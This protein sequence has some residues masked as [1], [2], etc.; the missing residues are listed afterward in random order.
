[1]V[2][3][4]PNFVTT[5]DA[6]AI[7][8]SYSLVD[9]DGVTAG[10]HY[11]SSGDGSSGTPYEI[12]TA[13]E[14]ANLAYLINHSTAGYRES[15]VCY[16]LTADIELNDWTDDGDGVVEEGELYNS[17]G[18]ALSW[19]PIGID[20]SHYFSGTFDG[21]EYTVSG[22][23]INSSSNYQGLF[24]DLENP[25]T[26]KN[27]GVI[28]SYISSS[29]NFVSGVVGCNW[30]T[31]QNCYNTGSVI[32]SGETTGG[33]VGDNSGT[34]Q[35]CY[36]AGSVSGI[37]FIG[38]VVGVNNDT[39]EYCYNT[40][41][42]TGT[43]QS[44]GGVAGQS[45]EL[46]YCYN[47]GR[48]SGF[49]MVGGITG[50]NTF[51]L[52]DCYNSGN[53]A[54]TTE[55]G[56][57][58]GFSSNTITRCY[59]T[60]SVSGSNDFGGVVGSLFSGTVTD[61]YYDKQMCLV[62]GIEGVDNLGSAEGELTTSMTSGSIGSSSGD[63]FYGFSA[64]T[65]TFTGGLY[66]RLADNGTFDMDGTDAAIVSATP[67]FLYDNTAAVA[68]D[69]E[70]VASVTKNFTASTA[71]S[72]SWASGKPGIVSISGGNATILSSDNTGLTLNASL[73]SVN[74]TII[75]SSV[76]HFCS[77]SYNSNG[78]SGTLP[79]QAPVAE[80][81]S[82]TVASASGLSRISYTFNIWS[83]GLGTH[84][85][86]STYS[87][88]TASV[89]LTAIW[90]ADAPSAPTLYGKTDT[91]IAVTAVSGQEYSIDGG[92]TWQSS[93]AFTGLS[94]STAYSIVSRVAT[95]GNDLASDAGPA[96][97]A[98]TNDPPIYISSYAI[99]VTANEG[100]VI[101][102]SS[103]TVMEGGNHTF[104]ITADEGYHIDDVLVDGISVGTV[105]IYTF[106]N[107]RKAHTI[108]ATFAED[109]WINPFE[110]VDTADWF[111]PAVEYVM[112]AGLMDVTGENTFSPAMDTSRGMIVTVLWRLENKPESLSSCSFSDVAIGEYYA[113]A[114]A[115]AEA[116]GI[117]NGYDS[118]NFGP[119]DT[120]TREQLAAILWR[121]AKYKDY[122]V[123]IG[124][125]TNILSYS[126][127]SDISE[128]AIPAIQWACGAGLLEGRTESTIVPDGSA[129]RAEVATMLMRLAEENISQGL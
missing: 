51:A 99:T 39:V 50:N 93:N 106:E 47:T 30:G 18:A 86:S 124:D 127:A 118:S 41:S 103:T 123:G 67:V 108:E 9:V 14:L 17:G 31:V 16:K 34:V 76:T 40:G 69:F 36:N 68:G 101:S 12:D 64:V 3:L 7:S 80:N 105:S 56:G 13:Q 78:G 57:I 94:A 61:C 32:C 54:A 59:N 90:K 70:T 33:V 52:Q 74:K 21:G 23:Y 87:T 96:L 19:T 28:D 25:G 71:S 81:G 112:Q 121:F 115:W 53:V 11:F 35:N 44:V 20:N 122:D 42:V 88:G 22:I 24:G 107:V 113:E 27:V 85:E 66:P 45:Y 104:T 38:G 129:S 49:M 97:N 1:M 48:V 79:T 82:F 77:V 92:G 15:A 46:Q 60:G 128:Y 8:W 26:V 75:I 65:W 95:S 6:A 5:A 63:A 111:Y 43:L 109:P 4:F 72:V 84:A 98:T 10:D 2:S 110:D 116:N 73:N 126:D 58:A 119:E 100:G 120:I 91:T 102:P 83:D 125:E 89:T 55:V 62:G 117:V 114:V 37:S 29:G